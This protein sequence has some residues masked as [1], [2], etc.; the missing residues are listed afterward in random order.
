MRG[1][2]RLC[3]KW[4]GWK[5]AQPC[6]IIVTPE[7]LACTPWDADQIGFP[8]WLDSSTLGLSRPTQCSRRLCSSNRKKQHAALIA[9]AL[10]F[11]LVKLFTS[12]TIVRT[13]GPLAHI[14]WVWTQSRS[15]SWL[16]CGD[17]RLLHIVFASNTKLYKQP[18][19]I[20]DCRTELPR[21]SMIVCCAAPVTADNFPVVA[22]LILFQK[23]LPF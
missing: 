1:V 7:I 6:I 13:H 11:P 19:V 4:Q 21:K 23:S 12:L 16:G 2:Q 15:C 10:I 17:I 8:N 20:T 14:L 18:H 3:R 22:K 5:I 9:C